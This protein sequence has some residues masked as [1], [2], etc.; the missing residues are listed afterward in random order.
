[1]TGRQWRIVFGA[2]AAGCTFLL[3]QPQVQDIPVL[4]IGLGLANIVVAYIKAP[5]DLDDP[6]A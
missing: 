4:A 2:I 6:A 1:M 3:L 5:P